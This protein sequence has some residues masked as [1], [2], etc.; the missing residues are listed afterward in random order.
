MNNGRPT[1]DDVFKLV[2]KFLKSRPVII[3]GSGATAPYGLPLIDDFREDLRSELGGIDS[4]VNLECALGK[5]EDEKKVNRIRD[6][7]KRKVLKSETACLNKFIRNEDYLL[8]VTKMI[9]KFY[10]VQ[11]QKID[12]VTTNYD[13]V[14]EYAISKSGYKYTDGFAGHALSKF[15][16]H[17]FGKNKTINIIKVHGSL[18][19]VTHNGNRLFLPCTHEIDGL[20]S[21]MI[22]PSKRKFQ[23]AYQ[24]PFRTLIAKSDRFIENA[25]SFLV[26]GFGFNDEHLTP[27]IEE[28]I[29][30]NTPI[31]IITKEATASC[32]QKIEFSPQH[33]LFEESEN[34]TKVIFRDNSEPSETHISGDYW[35]LSKFMEV[36]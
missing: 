36:I 33:C 24:E 27:K 19:W 23:D 8:P 18:N 35:N 21:V 29:K 3:W 34:Q 9:K 15:D 11:P 16:G 26:V 10:N 1:K 22:L 25:H 31:V 14:L 4:N 13:R 6:V 2:Q 7:V 12:I 28:K 5:I 17:S 32:R 20:K 30:Q